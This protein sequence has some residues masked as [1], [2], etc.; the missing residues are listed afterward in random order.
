MRRTAAFAILLVSLTQDKKPVTLDDLFKLTSI[1]DVKISPQGDRVAYVTSKPSLEKNQ[2]EAALFV[3]SSSGGTARRLAETT[4]IMNTPLPAPRLKW[5]PDGTRVS[6][7]GVGP[8]DRP[9]VFAVDASGAG[10]ATVMTEAPDGVFGYDW[11]P[12]GTS[13]AYLTRD[14]AT[15]SLVNHVDAPGPATRI[16][17]KPANGPARMLTPP[18]QFVENFS[19]APDGREIAYSAATISGFMAQYGGRIYAVTVDGQTRR[20]IVD[21]P[22]MNA[23]PQ[24]SP[25]GA[26][27]AFI[28][29]NTKISLMAPRGLAMTP[30]RA[31]RLSYIQSF[32]LDDAW[33]SDVIW[34]RDS[35][36]IFAIT[37]DGTYGQG[38]RMF[39]Q[40]IVRVFVDTG[41]TEV[42]A[43]G[44]N[45]TLSISRDGSKIAYRNVEP[46]TMGDVVVRDLATNRTTKVSDANPEL[47]DMALGDERAVSWRSFDG[48]EIWGLLITPPGAAGRR[49]P[50]LVYCHGGPNGSI[51]YGLF[52]QF[53]QTVP[54]VDYYPV[55][56]MVNA[57]FAIL[58]PMP[59]GG[60]GY[61][62]AGQRAIINDWG[63]ADYKDIMTGVDDLVAKGIADPDR[64]GVMGASYGGY[65]TEWV[66]TQTGRFKAASAGAGISSL[67][68]AYYL[69]DAGD[70]IAEYFKRPWEAP[71]SYKAHSPLTFADRVTTP[72]LIQH[73]E[74]DLRVPL[75]NATKFYRA[76]KQFNK[77]VELDIH[78]ASSHLF[79]LPLQEHEAMK[80]N[81]EWFQKWILK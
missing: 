15:P 39:E 10:L 58:F 49:L 25:D 55:Q 6:F 4:R 81:L 73:G 79:Y 67:E 32:P 48:K 33:V 54:Q 72:L 31:D 62:E 23:T 56:A 52:P 45:F 14:P 12:D 19:W 69:S 9:Q 36:S 53:M 7:I 57:G 26:R 2:H 16:A 30:G 78:P 50:L 59:R 22:G 46:R 18:D 3:V 29:T 61:G 44:A 66:V 51:T 24:Y 43:S 20:T 13:I 35:K 63:G 77:T 27:I 8:Q 64:L 70:P 28:T 65:M 80:R 75:A 11:S 17:L 47:R 40:A 5:A 38:A 60:V 76:L 37:T 68:D 21:R 71:E 74:R 41:R 1:V 42:I 34:A